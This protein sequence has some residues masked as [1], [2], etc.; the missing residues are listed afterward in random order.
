M[1][2]FYGLQPSWV[3]QI[4]EEEIQNPT[5]WRRVFG[6]RTGVRLPEQ[7]DQVVSGRVQAGG[8]SGGLIWT[9]LIPYWGRRPIPIA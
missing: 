2:G 1:A 6:V 9:A 8:A 5:H 7:S 4:L 3:S